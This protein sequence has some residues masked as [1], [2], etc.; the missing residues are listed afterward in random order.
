SQ[1]PIER[2]ALSERVRAAGLDVSQITARLVFMEK[3]GRL[4]RQ[5]NSIKI[6]KAGA[7]FLAQKTARLAPTEQTPAP[8]PAPAPPKRHG[9]RPPGATGPTQRELVL[10]ALKRAHPNP[11]TSIGLKNMLRKAGHT[12]YSSA[13]VAL[14]TLQAQ[15]RVERIG[16]GQY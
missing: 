6:T 16:T 1:L 12:T 3:G 15:K 10:A 7:E 5:G 8:A 4:T 14:H 11:V 13:S 2:A 9:G